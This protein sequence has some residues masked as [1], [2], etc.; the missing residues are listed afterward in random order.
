MELDKSKLAIVS[1]YFKA[2]QKY[3]SNKHDIT[4]AFPSLLPHSVVNSNFEKHLLHIFLTELQNLKEI[5]DSWERL[6]EVLLKKISII[7]F[8]PSKFIFLG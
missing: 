1:P 2:L 4:I 6:G 5:E 7:F 3:R 8:D